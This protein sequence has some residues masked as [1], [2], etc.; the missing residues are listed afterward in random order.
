[1]PMYIVVVS[2]HSRYAIKG[3]FEN[4]REMATMVFCHSLWQEC[5][6]H[7]AAKQLTASHI[8]GWPWDTFHWMHWW[9]Q[10]SHGAAARKFPDLNVLNL[11]LFNAIDKLQHKKPRCN[12]EELISA[13]NHTYKNLSPAVI[14]C[15]F[16]S[17]QSVMEQ[18]LIHDGDN[19]FPMPHM[20]KGK[21]EKEL[22]ELPFQNHLSAKA[23][24]KAHRLWSQQ[25][26]SH[27]IK[28]WGEDNSDLE[29]K[30]ELVPSHAAPVNLENAPPLCG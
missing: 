19:N 13:V 23:R 18:I 8:V 9:I 15:V 5:Q 11:G 4:T 6:N 12:V 24:R 30:V 22:G 27:H 21:T 7:G 25:R 28:M 17:L 29:H 14:N 20:G 10:H 3:F 1:M 2:H 16:V 26:C